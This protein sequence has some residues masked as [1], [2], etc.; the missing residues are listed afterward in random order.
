MKKEPGIETE[1]RA[2]EA[3]L[4]KH[5]RIDLPA[6]WLLRIFRKKTVPFLFRRPVAAQLLDMSAMYVRMNIDLKVLESG[7]VGV[8]FEHIA[9]HAVTSSRIIARGLIRSRLAAFFLVRPLAG[10]IMRHMDMQS[11]AELT[12]MIIF[13]SGGENFP[14]II[15][16]IAFMR[17]TAPILSHEE[18]S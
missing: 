2:A 6:P 5:L 9:K 12:K 1:A 4:D 11:L 8:L 17:I 7:E 13:L 14:P 16:S 15:R 18:G 10:Y 3:I